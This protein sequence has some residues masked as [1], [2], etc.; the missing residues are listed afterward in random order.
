MS[1][2]QKNVRQKLSVVFKEKLNKFTN[3]FQCDFQLISVVVD[4][5][6]FEEIFE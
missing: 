2:K 4:K 1:V 6:T 3:R 5:Q